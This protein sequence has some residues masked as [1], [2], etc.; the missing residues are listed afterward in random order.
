MVMGG[1]HLSPVAEAQVTQTIADLH[2]FD[3]ERIG[4]SHCTGPK[5]AARM[6]IEFGDR[7]FFC[8]VGKVVEA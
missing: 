3:I 6:A 2:T 1:T 5:V 4:V 8:S 7:F